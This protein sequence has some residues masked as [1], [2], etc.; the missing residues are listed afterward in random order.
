MRVVPVEGRRG[1]RQF[2]R[3]PW[4][5][6]RDD[7]AWE[8]M[9]SAAPG[10]VVT[11]GQHAE[12]TV[13]ALG[14]ALS[15]KETRPAPRLRSRKDL[16]Q[17]PLARWFTS[18][19]SAHERLV[20]FFYGAG[21]DLLDTVYV[22]LAID[23]EPE[24]EA[25]EALLKEGGQAEMALRHA[26]ARGSKLQRQGYASL[27]ELLESAA[28]G[29]TAERWVV[30]GEPGAGK[31]T[32]ARHLVWSLSDPAADPETRPVPLYLTLSRLAEAR[33]HPFD[34]AES[35]LVSSQGSRVGQR[36]AKRLFDLSGEPGK[37]WLLLDGFDEVKPE[38]LAFVMERLRVWSRE[39]PWVVVCVLSRPVG[40]Q[41]LGRDFLKARIRPLDPADQRAL[42]AKWL[43]E[44]RARTAT[45]EIV[46][47]PS[48]QDQA[49]NPLMLTLMAALCQETG[50][51]APRRIDMYERAID[52]LLDRG[53]HQTAT[54]VRD[55]GSAR[56]IVQTLSLDLQESGAQAW[57]ESA[58]DDRLWAVRKS[59]PE[60]VGFQLK[61]VWETNARFLK[62]LSQNSGI[63][64]PHDGPREPWRYL[65][66]SLREYL[67]AREL[68]RRGEERLLEKV[69]GLEE[70]EAGQWGETL[71]LAAGLLD[72]P[73][74]FLERLQEIN[75][76]VALDALRNIE[77]LSLDEALEFLWHTKDWDGDYLVALI[78][79][80][81][82]PLADVE[83]AL[84][85]QV[86]PERT[87]EQ[88]AYLHYAS[89]SD[90][91]ASAFLDRKFRYFENLRHKA[92][93][94]KIIGN[95]SFSLFS[96]F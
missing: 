94:Q 32:L 11:Y 56:R 90:Y 82:R 36:F 42:L 14:V 37:V 91:D 71:A 20:P 7:P 70:E 25:C 27:N 95:V 1:L 81:R 78:R 34:L 8:I 76:A 19:R 57:T 73:R 84:L 47:S 46:E 50:Q 18:Q 52:M 62:D 67:S 26:V 55:K 77:V 59:E 29:D 87:V 30:L 61:E 5:L 74:A 39:M 80:W 6:Y 3:L 17:D 41:E 96:S 75:P 54:G 16:P 22:E 86:V 49:R 69:R 65:H 64:G 9:A 66:R 43:G 48:L 13:R 85:A 12:A 72:S 15:L 89:G 35:D 60:Q 53:H 31:T 88:L 24:P 2:I 83:A 93:G 45:I 10:P 63:L 92:F 51:V 4:S 68:K 23:R 58:L 21:D 38:A 40:Y 28:N 44:E 33:R 79:A